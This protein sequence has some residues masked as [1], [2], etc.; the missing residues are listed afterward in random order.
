MDVKHKP[1]E[2]RN[3]HSSGTLINEPLKML[4]SIHLELPGSDLKKNRLKR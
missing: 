3:Y 4:F 2:F 1:Q